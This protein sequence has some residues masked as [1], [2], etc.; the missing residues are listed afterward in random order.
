[1]INME[2]SDAA[3]INI[4]VYYTEAAAEIKYKNTIKSHKMSTYNILES[5]LKTKTIYK[6][7]ISRIKTRIRALQWH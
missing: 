6:S 7:A 2:A 1:M 5:L 4:I 3:A